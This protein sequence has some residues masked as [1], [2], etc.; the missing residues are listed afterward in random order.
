MPEEVAPKRELDRR[1]KETAERAIVEWACEIARNYQTELHTMVANALEESL[2]YHSDLYPRLANWKGVFPE[3]WLTYLD[4]HNVE[5][6]R[7]RP[8]L[9]VETRER[10][11]SLEFYWRNTPMSEAEIASYVL[12][13]INKSYLQLPLV[14]AL[15]GI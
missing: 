2:Q 11:F 12:G 5:Q 3:P 10:L 8:D 4:R 1:S 15:E 9:V 14:E 7:V 13:K 6:R